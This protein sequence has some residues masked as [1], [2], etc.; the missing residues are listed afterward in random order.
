MHQHTKSKLISRIAIVAASVAVLFLLMA[1]AKASDTDA[2][3][4]ENENSALSAGTPSVSS[5]IGASSAEK[6]SMAATESN[7]DKAVAMMKKMS[8]SEKIGQM[9]WVSCPTSDATAKKYI[10]TYHLGG[11]ILFAANF[12]NETK[13]SLKKELASYQNTASV[14]LAFAVDE[15]GGTVVRVSKYKAFRS[16]PY[17]SVQDVYKKGGYSALASDAK[18]KAKLLSS[19][20]INVN[21]APVADVSTNSSDYIYARTLGKGPKATA[22]YIKKV[23]TAYNSSD[24]T[25]VLKHF[26]GYGSNKNTH[27]GSATDKR[28]LKTLQ[29]RDLIPFTS[30][31]K[32]GAPIIMV[33]HN[34]Y[35]AFDKKNPASISKKVHDYLRDTMGYKGIIMTDSL[36]MEAVSSKS[37]PF[38]RA[39]KAGNDI[40]CCSSPTMSIQGYKDIKAAIKSGSVSVSQ[41]NKS[42]ERILEWKM[43]YGII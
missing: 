24:F 37:K 40:M 42:V 9:I 30:G 12:E 28:S 20:G 26:P 13:S 43:D 5:G 41:I 18:S 6:S 8:V 16:T 34:V 35:Y 33:S 15:E 36:S 31:I 21:L 39:V 10:K 32:A 22:T 1:C 2:S 27:T 23:E 14:P 11:M 38:V 7:Y 29:S 4:L 17:K 19:I 3:S 25:S